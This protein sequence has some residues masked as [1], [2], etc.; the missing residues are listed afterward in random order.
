[1]ANTNTN[2]NSEMAQQVMEILFD[3]K[4]ELGDGDFLRCCDLLK[5]IHN[6]DKDEHDERDKKIQE[7][8]LNIELMKLEIKL[9]LINDIKNYSLKQNC[10]RVV[11]SLRDIL[12]FIDDYTGETEV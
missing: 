4:E 10:K 9:R 7:L 1:M 11:K 3:K 8:Q 6:K 5:N 2:T 12:T